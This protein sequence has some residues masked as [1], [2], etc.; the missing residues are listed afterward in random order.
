MAQSNRPQRGTPV[1]PT[2]RLVTNESV[3]VTRS[4]IA[5]FVQDPDFRLVA[6]VGHFDITGAPELDDMAAAI[7]RQAEQAYQ[8]VGAS[9]RHELSLRPLLVLYATTGELRAAVQT[10]TVPGKRE[11]LLLPLD[12]PAAR[13]DGVLAHEIS[14]MFLFDM[15]PASRQVPSWLLEGLAELH[16]GEW[17]PA[18]VAALKGVLA[19]GVP[20]LSLIEAGDDRRNRIIGHAMF[21]FLVMRVGVDGPTRLLTSLTGNPAVTS[22]DAY[23][24]VAGVSPDEFNRAF[25]VFVKTRLLAP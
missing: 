7:G 1:I 13:L 5:A 17:Q 15:L 25:D 24:G 20:T 22:I 12:I 14:H 4:P 23:L 19:E 18:D 9:L 21:D 2:N 8:R 16:R 11:H 10:R 6:S 3:V